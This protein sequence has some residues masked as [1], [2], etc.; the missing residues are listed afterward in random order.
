MIVFELIVVLVG[1]RVLVLLLLK[2]VEYKIWFNFVKIFK[3]IEIV[4][5]F[6]SI[7]WLCIDD[8]CDVVVV[9]C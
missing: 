4:F 8:N 1:D 6:L 9:S 2:I 7:K 5:Y 3:F